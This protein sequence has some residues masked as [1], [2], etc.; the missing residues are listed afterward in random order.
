MSY[1]S[2]Q[3]EQKEDEI[4]VPCHGIFETV[5]YMMSRVSIDHTS[6]ISTTYGREQN[7]H[8]PSEIGRE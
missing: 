4:T 3:S 8:C 7:H 6:L 1:R 5:L 2:V